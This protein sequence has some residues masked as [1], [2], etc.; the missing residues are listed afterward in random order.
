M[1]EI[2]DFADSHPKF[3]E[4][5]EEFKMLTDPNMR[6]DYLIYYAEKFHEVPESISI[7]PY[8]N[9]N[10]VPG[11]ESQAYVWAIDKEDGTI[12]YYFAVENP[13]G[14]SAKAMAAILDELTEDT[15]LDIIATIP[16]E[17]VYSLFGSNLPM[18]RSSGLQNMVAMVRAEA[19]RRILNN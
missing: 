2:E 12:K 18:V 8:P 16:T 9:S 15:P 11:C 10:K 14:I 7:K 19:K 5:L 1:T 6:A 4:M 13:Q 3:A 17:I